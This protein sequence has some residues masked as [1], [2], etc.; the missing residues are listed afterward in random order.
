MRVC[1]VRPDLPALDRLFDY[2][3]PDETDVG[4]GTI[5]RV[6][7]HGRSVRG[8]VVGVDVEPA[9]DLERLRPLK[10]VVGEGPPPELVELAD[11]AAWRWAGTPVP[12]LRVASPALVVPRPAA[13]SEVARLPAPVSGEPVREPPRVTVHRW[14]PAA[15]RAELVNRLVAETGST[16]V[17]LA[18]GRR[19]PALVRALAAA[20]SPS[21]TPGPGLTSP[22]RPIVVLRADRSD[23]ERTRAWT[24][25]RSG[26]HIVVGGRAAVWAPVP[27]L[28][29]I[30]VLDEGD[31]A[32]EEERAPT[33]HARE[34]A[35][36]RA[37]RVGARVELVSAAPTV[38]AE[39]AASASRR[40]PRPT[41]REGWPHVEVVDRRTE[42][43]GSGLL[44]GALADGFRRALEGRGRAVAVLNRKGRARLLACVA[45]GELARCET[46]GAAV[47]ESDAGSLDCP[48]DATTRPMV[49][50]AC[51]GAR[52]K[53]VRPGVSRLR[54]DVAAL[55][56]R[57]EVNEVDATTKTVP[58]VDVLVGTEA[59]LHRI[60]HSTSRPI[61][62]IAFC[63]FD[64]EL[65]APR[66]RAAEQA[67]NL[68]V[69]AARLVGPRSGP[70]RLL[71]QTRVPDHEVVDAAVRGD[72]AGALAAERAR[73]EMLGDPPFGGLAEL[74]GSPPAVTALVEALRADPTVTVVG[75]IDVGGAKRALVRAASAATL[76]DA[77]ADTVRAARAHGRL[78]VD[79]DPLRL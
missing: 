6:P 39:V 18:D 62:T 37:R 15:P 5:V 8:W 1:R 28:A 68:L 45:C 46:C 51:H 69:R 50:L 65:L 44:S 3:V 73:R 77:L 29:A 19:T 23:P 13:S 30:I 12:F 53:A 20:P 9:T 74:S 47:I 24:A 14:P 75:S 63:D 4:V 40:P 59:V 10:K 7:L 79:V 38:E 11:W 57:A 67:M 54:D 26:H 61:H 16:I 52:M 64:Q 17:V 36:E 2:S 22:R 72:P 31:E 56:P 78:R 58:I 43:P 25:A 41:E 27:D 55:L 32:L 60:P 34:V 48:R 35:I 71:V 33:W 42:R 21:P 76:A 66:P 70:G 49:C